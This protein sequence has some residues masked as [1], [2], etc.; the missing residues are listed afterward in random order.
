MKQHKMCR[1]PN[2][3]PTPDADH[4]ESIPSF[5]Y[6]PVR[7]LTKICM[8]AVTSEGS[9]GTI[10]ALSKKVIRTDRPARPM[11]YELYEKGKRKKGK[12]CTWNTKTTNK[13][14]VQEY[15]TTN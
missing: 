3:W 2:F 11:G 15:H 8:V 10:T 4:H 7:V 13:N 14:I 6:L 9:T 5:H 1:I 12:G